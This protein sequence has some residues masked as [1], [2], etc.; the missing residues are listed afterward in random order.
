VTQGRDGHGVV[1]GMMM[2]GEV[3][4]IVVVILKEEEVEEVGG[5][6]R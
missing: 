3:K 1:V 2:K 4:V 5:E 6:D